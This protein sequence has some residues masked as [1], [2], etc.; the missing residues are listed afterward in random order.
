MNPVRLRRRLPA[1]VLVANNGNTGVSLWKAADLTSIG[2]VSTG[3]GTHPFGACSDG[4]SFW[5]T[6]A[7]SQAIARF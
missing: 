4:V 5:V 2:V 7:T 6:L 1:F 3:A